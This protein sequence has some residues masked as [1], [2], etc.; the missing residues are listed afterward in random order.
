LYR[1][2]R[3]HFA[4]AHKKVGAVRTQLPIQTNN[5]VVAQD[6]ANVKRF[7]NFWNAQRLTVSRYVPDFDDVLTAL[8]RAPKFVVLVEMAS[9]EPVCM[10]CFIEDKARI[11]FT[12]AERM[13][14]SVAVKQL[15]LLGSVVLGD[16]TPKTWLQFLNQIDVRTTYDFINLGEVLLDSNLRRAVAQLPIRYQVSSPSRKEQIRWLIDLPSEFNN[17]ILSLRP[18]SRQIIRQSLRKFEAGEGCSFSIISEEH[19]IDEFLS[20]GEAISRNT[21]QWSVGQRLQNDTA[22]RNEYIRLARSGKLRCYILRINGTPCAFARGSLVGGIYNYETPGFLIEYAKW[23]PGTVLLMLAIKDLIEVAKCRFFDFGTGGDDVGYKAK[24]G[25]VSLPARTLLISRRVALR[26]TLIF[27]AQQTL[28]GFKNI[29][30][31]V[32]GS[33]ELRRRIRRAMRN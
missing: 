24:F 14:G 33:G 21:Y 8:M 9:G 13:L 3:D 18:K 28:I 19:Q 7:G 29:A 10:G 1:N 6:I 31:R 17:Y 22:T 12:V 30:D 11:P 23:S 20:I 16:L 25:N 32:L 4:I 27:L 26:P 5:I 15:A 2:E